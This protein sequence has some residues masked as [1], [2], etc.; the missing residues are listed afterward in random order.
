[1]RLI[2]VTLPPG[3]VETGNKPA[4]QRIAGIRHHD[5]DGRGGPFS[6]Q[7]PKGSDSPQ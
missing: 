3:R 5:R 2:P 1:M 4:P 6:R 7:R